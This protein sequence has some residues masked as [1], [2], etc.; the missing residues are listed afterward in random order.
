MALDW[1]KPNVPS[2]VD[3]FSVSAGGKQ[4]GGDTSAHQMGGPVGSQQMGDRHEPRH[5]P[6]SVSLEQPWIS[7]AAQ[8][9]NTQQTSVQ[10]GGFNYPSQQMG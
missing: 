7:G 4:M 2:H 6:G 8:Q 10:M 5:A 3:H 1:S 9:P